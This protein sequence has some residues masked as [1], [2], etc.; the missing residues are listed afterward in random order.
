MEHKQSIAV[1]WDGVINSYT[2]GWKRDNPLHNDEPIPGAIAFLV[3]ML[4]VFRVYIYS[5]R[6][7]DSMQ[8]VSMCSWLKRH[9]M[10]PDLVDELLFVSQKPASLIYL[11]DR[12][13]RFNGRF[14]T[15]EEIRG[16]KPWNKGGKNPLQE[17]LEGA[18]VKALREAMAAEPR[19]IWIEG[20]D[21]D[22]VGVT[23][24]EE[25]NKRRRALFDAVF[26][27]LEALAKE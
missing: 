16:F 7:E 26:A 1:D 24:W 12:A 21:E 27:R 17:E 3:S 5:T 19:T 2:S 8:V 6:C 23:Q 13:W 20:R 10:E 14:P 15:A 18:L 11:D 9:G 4:S 22:M 25:L